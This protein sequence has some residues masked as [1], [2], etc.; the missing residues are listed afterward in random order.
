VSEAFGFEKGISSGFREAPQ[1]L[2]I[3]TV[4]L[5]AGALVALIPNVPFIQV[6]LIV[7]VVNAMLLPIVL[8]GALRL[9]NDRKVMGAYTNG[10][11]FNAV[12]VLT[13]VVVTVLSTGLLV[14]TVL[15]LVGIDVGG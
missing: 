14:L 10:P 2:S 9:T 11:V 1:F 7:Q 5:V 8:V 13:A 4:L 6:L 12:A 3:F 15:P